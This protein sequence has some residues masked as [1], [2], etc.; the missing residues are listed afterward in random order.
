MKKIF[1]LL[2]VILSTVS[3][4]SQEISFEKDGR[5]NYGTI[6]HNSNGVREI[7]VKNV[8]TQPLL[9]TNVVGQCG[10]TT[11][12]D[13]EL[14]GWTIKPILPNENGIIKIK[15]D[16]KRIGRFDKMITIYSNDIKGNRVVYIYG[17]VLEPKKN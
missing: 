9:I 4:K 1:L 2:T 14:P 11:A 10:C 8:G 6:E 17:N 16:T 13:G 7:V 15:Y 3:I 5:L 12:M